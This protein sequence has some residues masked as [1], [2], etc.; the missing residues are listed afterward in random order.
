MNTIKE[1]LENILVNGVKDPSCGICYELDTQLD[2]DID[3]VV[4]TKN[5]CV[6]W[7]H[8]SGN[9]MFPVLNEVAGLSNLEIYMKT[10][11]LWVGKQGELRRSLVRHLIKKCEE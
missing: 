10:S 1:V 2:I 8:Y 6:D 9:R 11:N 4:W 3:P 7:K 5:A